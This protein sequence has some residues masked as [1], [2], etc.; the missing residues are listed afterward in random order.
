MHAYYRTGKRAELLALL[1]VTDAYFHDKDRWGEGPLAAL[2]HSTLENHLFAES[3]AYYEE[4][5]PLHQRTHP[6]RGVGNG[7]L[8]NYYGHAAD[9]YAGLGNTRKAVDRASGAV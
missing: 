6:R 3:A 5:I 9:A 2:A 7:T 1:K 8:S 4:L